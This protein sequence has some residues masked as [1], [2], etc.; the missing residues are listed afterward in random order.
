M[1]NWKLRQLLFSHQNRSVL[2]TA[3]H[4]VVLLGSAGIPLYFGLSL[5]NPLEQIRL[6]YG[7][8]KRTSLAF[9]WGLEGWFQSAGYRGKWTLALYPF[10]PSYKR[11]VF[12]PRES[13]NACES[14]AWGHGNHSRGIFLDMKRLT[15]PKSWQGKGNRP[16]EGQNDDIWPSTRIGSDCHT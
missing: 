16:S 13:Y 1:T 5:C 15:P 14:G 8:W 9:I 10:F 2:L 4:S 11:R 3:L 7:K 12:W 6:P